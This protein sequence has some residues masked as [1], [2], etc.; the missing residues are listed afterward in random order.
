MTMDRIFAVVVCLCCLGLCAVAV[1][2]VRLTREASARRTRCRHRWSDWHECVSP[3]LEYRVCYDCSCKQVED[4][5][6]GQPRWIKDIQQRK[7]T[8]KV[9]NQRSKG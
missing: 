5:T 2:A 4:V 6:E 8:R 1:F 7:L 3:R 9:D